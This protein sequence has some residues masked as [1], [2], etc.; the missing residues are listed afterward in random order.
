MTD[1]ADGRL[2]SAAHIDAASEAGMAELTLPPGTV[3]TPL[4]R[5]RADALGV[6]LKVGSATVST[7]AAGTSRTALEAKAREV[8]ARVV[9]KEGGDPAM[10]DSLVRTALDRMGRDCPC[11]KHGSHG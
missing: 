4:A 3:V 2:V 5:E 7:P 9:A 10:V 6:A 11:G 1:S 8:A